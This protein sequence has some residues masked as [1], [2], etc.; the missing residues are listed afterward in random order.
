MILL[1][2]ALFSANLNSYTF[3]FWLPAIIKHASGR[4][5][6]ASTLF[7]GLPYALALLATVVVSYLSDR[8]GRRRFYAIV[9]MVV[10]GLALIASS[11]SGQP[12]W[13]LMLW[14]CL[15]GAGIYAGSPS[16]WVLS[17]VTLQSSAAAASIGMINAI[18][19][20]SGYVA[21]PIVGNLLDHGWSDAQVVRLAACGPL[22]GAVLVASFAFRARPNCRWTRSRNSV[23]RRPW[24]SN[25]RHRR[26]GTGESASQEPLFGLREIGLSSDVMHAAWTGCT[27][28]KHERIGTGALFGRSPLSR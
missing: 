13:L 14:L 21:S 22:I 6:I 15:A 7:S 16:F 26:A 8:S 20:F 12:F 24:K 10:T 3:V 17:T 9:P 4:S 23:P 25:D 11:Q 5:V 28:E 19:N 27:R 1:A 18:A 2:F